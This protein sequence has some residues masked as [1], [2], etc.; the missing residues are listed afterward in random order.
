MRS[1]IFFRRR[2]AATSQRPDAARAEAPSRSSAPTSS[3][4]HETTSRKPSATAL[5]LGNRPTS[6]M[7]APSTRGTARRRL[8]GVRRARS[9]KRCHRAARA[10]GRRTGAADRVSTGNNKPLYQA[11]QAY[12]DGPNYVTD[13]IVFAVDDVLPKRCRWQR[14]ADRSG[15]DERKRDLAFRGNVLLAPRDA[16]RKVVAGALGVDPIDGGPV[17]S[18]VHP[19][20]RRQ[21]TPSRRAPISRIINSLKATPVAAPRPKAASHGGQASRPADRR[22]RQ[23]L[24]EDLRRPA[25]SRPSSRGRKPATHS[26]AGFSLSE[27]NRALSPGP[28]CGPGWWRPARPCAPAPPRA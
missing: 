6:T 23:S 2:S 14:S 1:T 15:I 25:T 7:K 3:L 24:Q 17:M 28:Y 10:R 5:G 13:P 8:R 4:P 19:A 21:G 20:G 26:V 11:L 27:T 22:P 12:I 9:P 18:S 16:V